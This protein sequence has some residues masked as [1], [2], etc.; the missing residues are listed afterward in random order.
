MDPYLRA[1]IKYP[2][3]KAQAQAQ[4]EKRKGQK[5]TKPLPVVPDKPTKPTKKPTTK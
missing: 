5:E 1:A 3:L 2:A 4:L